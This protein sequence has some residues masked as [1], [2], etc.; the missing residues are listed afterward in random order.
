MF[1]KEIGQVCSCS[2]D[3]RHGKVRMKLEND[4]INNQVILL[5]LK[6]AWYWFVLVM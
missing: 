3:S 6:I 4:S 5:L 1:K 2:D